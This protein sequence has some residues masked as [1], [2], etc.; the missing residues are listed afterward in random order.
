M[1]LKVSTT[2]N[3]YSEVIFSLCSCMYNIRYSELCRLLRV[4]LGIAVY[5]KWGNLAWQTLG[6]CRYLPVL[7]GTSSTTESQHLLEL[8]STIFISLLRSLDYMEIVNNNRRGLWNVPYA[9]SCYLLSGALLEELG[10]DLYTHNNLDPDMAMPANVRDS[11]NFIY[12]SNRCHI[13]F[14]YGTFLIKRLNFFCYRV[15]SDLISWI[16][17]SVKC[18]SLDDWLIIVVYSGLHILMK[19]CGKW[20]ELKYIRGNEIKFLKKFV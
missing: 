6:Q 2:W 20:I 19:C 18:F 12:V 5:L 11:G 4:T 17:C 10:P 9:S 16:L 7:L 15:N 13:V 1:I 8:K 3:R 14:K